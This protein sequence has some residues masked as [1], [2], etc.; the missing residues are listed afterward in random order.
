LTR[1][2]FPE[3]PA[4]RKRLWSD[5]VGAEAFLAHL[6]LAFE[7]LR[8]DYA[9]MRLPFA[10]FLEQGRGVVHGGAIATLI[11]SVVV[12]AVLSAFD[13][14]P[15]RLATIDLHVHYLDAVLREDVVAEAFVRRRGRSI[16]FVAVDARAGTREVAHGES[17][18]RIVL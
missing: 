6:G 13:E 16:V 18:W 11:D 3:I 14:R 5:E 1:E 8:L 2:D 12:G 10:P 9:R 7:D 17:S 4:E 15:R